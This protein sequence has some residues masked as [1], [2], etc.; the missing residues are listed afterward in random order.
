M[1]SR[2]RPSAAF[3]ATVEAVVALPL[4]VSGSAVTE[5]G[6]EETA[7]ESARRVTT[8]FIRA[9]K[10]KD[11]DAVTQV[12]A[13]P[14]FD[15]FE[16]RLIKE[17]SELKQYWHHKLR[18]LDPS[19]IPEKEVSTQR[20][21]EFRKWTASFDDDETNE[22]FRKT[23]AAI[24][25]ELDEVLDNAGWIVRIPDK[26]SSGTRF[27]LIRVRGGR[28][29]VVG[30]PSGDAYLAVHSRIPEEARAALEKP[31]RFELFSLEP[32]RLE[33]NEEGSFRWRK[34]LGS[35]VIKDAAV[36]NKI[37]LSLKQA[38][39]EGGAAFAGCFIPRH[40]IRVTRDR[41]D[42]DFLV[43]FE[44]RS[45]LLFSRDD[46]EDYDS[47]QITDLPQPVFDGVLRA[48]G[49]RLA[50]KPKKPD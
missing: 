15:P 20:Y 14:W 26:H 43:C 25:R 36:R 41:K 8:E 2:K 10:A 19:R 33:E 29:E 30:G 13:V 12:C 21:S 49:I 37:V 28:F 46:D 3:W 39:E 48:A 9:I 4:L 34:V 16:E 5:G 23:H 40:G 38:A 45:V 42:F 24:V 44:C 1:T 6:T 18:E 47:F 27:I 32:A 7:E 35:T 17:K 50:E 31:D 11:I 22:A